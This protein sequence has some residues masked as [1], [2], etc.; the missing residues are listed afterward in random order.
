MAVRRPTQHGISVARSP[1]LVEALR[2][3]AAQLSPRA[4]LETGTYLGQGTTRLLLE[5]LADRPPQVFFTIEVSPAFYAEAVLNLLHAPFVH[6]IWGLTVGQVEAEQFIRN[7]DLLRDFEKYPDLYIDA[8]QP[9]DAYLR[10]VRGAGGT[11]QPLEII[12][13][14]WLERLLPRI[15]DQRPLIALDSAGGIGWFEFQELLR[16]MQMAPFG[17]FLDDINHVKH[18]RSFKAVQAD[19]RFRLVD[20][21]YEQGWAVALFTPRARGSES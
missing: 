18:Y 6:C 19:A 12:P 11:E 4:V 10:E 8:D 1:R 2:Q 20:H 14:M 3:A 7:D 15:R 21:D 17:L 16:L 13:D 9:V 5:A